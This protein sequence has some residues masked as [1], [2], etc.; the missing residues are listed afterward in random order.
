MTGPVNGLAPGFD[1]CPS[2]NGMRMSIYDSRGIET[3]KRR[4]RKCLDCDA[5]WETMETFVRMIGRES[6]IYNR[7]KPGVTSG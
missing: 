7:T 4:R 2:C 6:T 3:G 5:R 1:F